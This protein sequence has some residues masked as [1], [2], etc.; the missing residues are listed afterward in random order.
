MTRVSAGNPKPWKTSADRPV[1]LEIFLLKH[2]YVLP[3]SQFLYAEGSD[4]EVRIAFATHD[5][6]VKGAGL[7]ALLADLSVQRVAQLQEAT[8]AERLEHS[9]AQFIREISVLKVDG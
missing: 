1:S 5:V 4:D 2:K 7:D 9:G 6:F 3:W 8:R